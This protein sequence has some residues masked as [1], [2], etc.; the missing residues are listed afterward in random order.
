ML[1]VIL[2]S[3]IVIDLGVRGSLLRLLYGLL[4]EQGFVARVIIAN[5]TALEASEQ[6]G[7]M[8]PLA[9]VAKLKDHGPLAGLQVAATDDPGV[10]GVGL[11]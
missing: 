5:Q 7:C 6:R 10:G 4:F 9:A 8:L 2:V 3:S 1:P 11:A